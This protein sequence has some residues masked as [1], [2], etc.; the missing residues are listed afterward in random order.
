MQ[1]EGGVK[2]EIFKGWGNAFRG[3]RR[4]RTPLGIACLLESGQSA[5]S[6]VDR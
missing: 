1:R 4:L 6:G 5:N 3:V 2:D